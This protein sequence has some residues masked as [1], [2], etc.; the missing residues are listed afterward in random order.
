MTKPRVEFAR[1]TEEVATFLS[2]WKYNFDSEQDLQRGI[3]EAIQ[4][5]YANPTESWQREYRLS[6]EDRIDFFYTDFGIGVEAKISHSLTAL[7]RQLHRYAQHEAIRGLVLITPKTRLTNLPDRI[8]GK[9][10]R[11]VNLMSSLL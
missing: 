9:P 11:I 8:N 10:I 4:R 3:W 7:T 6:E 1:D 5:V 2:G